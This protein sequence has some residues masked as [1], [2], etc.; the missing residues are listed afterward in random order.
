MNKRIQKK[1][2]QQ[3]LRGGIKVYNLGYP[4][5]FTDYAIL[6]LII[7]PMIEPHGINI[8]RPRM[9]GLINF[10]RKRRRLLD[11]SQYKTYI[12]SKAFM[13]R[14]PP[15]IITGEHRRYRSSE[16]MLFEREEW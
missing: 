11:P 3:K 13:M 5:Y 7:L 4:R 14:T 15:E 16:F 9:K 1:K 6:T 12:M 8:S 10:I 2:S